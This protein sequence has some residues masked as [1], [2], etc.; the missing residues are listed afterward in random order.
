MQIK[1]LNKG[2]VIPAMEVQNIMMELIS[3]YNTFEHIPEDRIGPLIEYE[4]MSNDGESFIEFI[5]Q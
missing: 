2:L 3:E 5:F 1:L 4:K